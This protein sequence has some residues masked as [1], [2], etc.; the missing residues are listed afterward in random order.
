MR[1]PTTVGEPCPRPGI[2]IFHKTLLVSLHRT[3]AFWPGAAMPSRVGPR[4]AGQSF[5]GSAASDAALVESVVAIAHSNAASRRSHTFQPKGLRLREDSFSFGFT[6][7][8]CPRRI[9]LS[10]AHS[11]SL[12]APPMKNCSARSS[13]PRSSST[14]TRVIR[15][16]TQAFSPRRFDRTA[17]NPPLGPAAA[18]FIKA[19]PGRDKSD[20]SRLG[21]DRSWMWCS[22]W[23]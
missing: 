10:S 20:S 4:Q 2:G 1:L 22:R 23:P 6:C 9:P 3:G 12:P 13:A 11:P 17:G 21:T 19:A 5:A 14:S 18:R 15:N 8:D 7:S 16:G